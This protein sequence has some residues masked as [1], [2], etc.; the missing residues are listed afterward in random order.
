MY[1]NDRIMVFIPCYRCASQIGRVLRQ[2]TQDL[3]KLIA[4]IVVVD[5]RSPDNT[6]NEAKIAL[7]EIR[8]CKKT[9]LL[10]CENYNLGGSHK[11]AFDYF[12]Q[13]GHDYIIVLHGDDQGSITDLIP[14]LKRGMHRNVDSLLGSRFDSASKLIGYSLFRRY[15]NV[16]FNLL[17]SLVTRRWVTDMGA[18][19]NLY[20][21]Q[22]LEN[23]FYLAFPND[24]TFNVFMLYYSIWSRSQFSFFPLTWREDDQVSN[25]KIFRQA[26]IILKLTIQFMVDP[27]RLFPATSATIEDSPYKSDIIFTA[28]G[29]K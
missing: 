11:V 19:L 28:D 7:S 6:I 29:L 8:H 9:L 13:A 4:E 2:F 10:N 23:R 24:L 14:L 21:R 16:A 27:I 20:R 18:G 15:G 17:I 12:L 22:F 3:Q 5:N 26:W 25:A 1:N